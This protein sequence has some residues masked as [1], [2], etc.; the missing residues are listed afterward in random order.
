MLV[1]LHCCSHYFQPYTPDIEGLSSFPGLVL[2]SHC[3]RKPG[4]LANKRILVVGTGSS[5]TDIM[6]TIAPCV[7]WVYLVYHRNLV[8]TRLPQNGEQLPPIT[9]VDSDGT[10][11]FENGVA[12]EIDV[13]I[14]CT[15][16]NYCFPFLT[17]E[18]GIKV[19][20]GKRVAPL[21]KHIFCATHP[22]LAFV[23]LNLQIIP[24]LCFDTQVSFIM[25]MLTGKTRLPSVQDMI[26]DGESD[27]AWRLE[28][29]IPHHHA[30]KLG[31]RQF[32]YYRQLAK[33]GNL[34]PFDPVY[35]ALYTFSAKDRKADV[36]NYKK[37]D[38]TVQKENDEMLISKQLRP[39]LSS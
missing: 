5:G 30:H 11:H 29:G 9:K 28:H 21:Y 8:T 24:F 31:S 22:S 3:Y 7:K 1:L 27:L 4:A 12:R 17:T 39:E 14:L 33:I 2:H 26:Q 13:I 36:L 38:Y 15:G 25:S 34:E 10:V 18:S 32:D 35:E 6:A 20:S 16:Y 37:Y 19:E 23:G